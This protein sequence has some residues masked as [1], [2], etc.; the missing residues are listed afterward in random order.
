[1]SHKVLIE[2]N[3]TQL[4]AVS[5]VEIESFLSVSLYCWMMHLKSIKGTLRLSDNKS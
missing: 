2:D 5:N 4:I 1:M 3:E